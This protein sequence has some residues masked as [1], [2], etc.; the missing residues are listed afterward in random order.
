MTAGRKNVSAVSSKDNP[1]VVLRDFINTNEPNVQSILAELK[2]LQVARG[3]NESE[4]LKILLESSIITSD[5]KVV[6]KEFQKRAPLFK[7]VRE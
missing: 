6:V 5:P 7:K 4:K 2:R 1:I 3:F